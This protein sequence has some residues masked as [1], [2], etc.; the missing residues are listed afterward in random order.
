MR[1]PTLYLGEPSPELFR[2]A[3]ELMEWLGPELQ[4]CVDIAVELSK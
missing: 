3:A 1:A 2:R 4:T